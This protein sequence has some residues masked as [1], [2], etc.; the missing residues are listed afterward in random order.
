MTTPQ[1]AAQRVAA[2]AAEVAG[3]TGM[4]V[5][6]VVENM[7]H[8]V[9]PC[10]GEIT[11]PFGEG[12][13]Q[14]L[15]DELGVP[16]LAQV[17][18]DEPLRIG[19]DVGMP[20]VLS[21]PDSPVGSGRDR[22]GRAAARCAAPAPRRRADQ[23]AARGSVA[24]A[25]RLPQQPQHD[26]V[27]PRPVRVQ[28]LLQVLDVGPLGQRLVAELSE[29]ARYLVA[30]VTLEREKVC[31]VGAPEEQRVDVVDASQLGPGSAWSS[32]RRSSRMSLLPP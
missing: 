27:D 12:G 20:L 9:C 6:G 13:G 30:Q 21:Q 11:R 3:K 10:C 2:R 4:R 8:L 31:V 5:A 7:S 16:L 32:T 19:A 23:E 15:A 28:P 18:L 26:R 24:L 1:P 29:A 14:A 25:G 17:P 22:A